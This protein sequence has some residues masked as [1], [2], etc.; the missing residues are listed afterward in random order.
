MSERREQESV[1]KKNDTEKKKGDVRGRYMK[2][3]KNERKDMSGQKTERGG[4]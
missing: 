4:R 2:G 1:I 3:N